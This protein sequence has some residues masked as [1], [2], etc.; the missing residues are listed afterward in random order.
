MNESFS[1]FADDGN[2]ID[3]CE[4]FVHSTEE[5]YMFDMSAPTK[6]IVLIPQASFNG[7]IVLLECR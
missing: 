1:S 6:L 4:I 7:Q 2:L 3:E 5:L